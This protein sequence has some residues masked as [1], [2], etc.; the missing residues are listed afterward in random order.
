MP[1][2]NQK[3]SLQQLLGQTLSC[4]CEVEHVVPT[5]AVLL[6]AG[7]LNRVARCCKR[8]LPGQKVLLVSDDMTHKVAGGRVAE[9]M[10]Q[11][12]LAFGRTEYQ[13][14]HANHDGRE[15]IRRGIMPP[16]SGR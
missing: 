14:W 11:A 2:V 12:G 5:K 7:A 10:Q 6:E 15:K 9:I 3:F 13:L 4:T 1:Y 8:Y 16:L